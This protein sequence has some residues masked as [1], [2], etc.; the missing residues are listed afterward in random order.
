MQNSVIHTSLGLIGVGVGV[1][2]KTNNERLNVFISTNQQIHCL[3]FPQVLFQNHCLYAYAP[4]KSEI[5][6]PEE[7]TA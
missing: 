5:G 7:Q 2:L 1:L 4:S 6:F 3:C